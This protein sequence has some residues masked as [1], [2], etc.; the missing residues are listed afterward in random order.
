[1][2]ARLAREP[3]E[4]LDV[5]LGEVVL[6]IEVLGRV[7]GEGELGQDDEF[8]PRVAGVGDRRGDQPGVALDVADGGVDLGERNRQ[9]HWGVGSLAHSMFRRLTD[10]AK[11]GGDGR[12]CSRPRSAPSPGRARLA[13]QAP[14]PPT[15]AAASQALQAAQQAL[16]A[17]RRP[18]A[19]R[20]RRRPR[21]R[22]SP[23]TG[24][25]PPTPSSGDRAR[26][27]ARGLLARPTDG[28]ADRFGDGYPA[29]APV[30]SAESPHFCVFW[31]SDPGYADAPDLADPNG[32]PTATGPRLRR[33][34]DR[35]R[36]ALLR[37][38]GRAGTARLGAPEARHARAVAPTR[39]CGR[40]ST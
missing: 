33:V 10:I 12:P 32:S 20:D 35:D 23:S 28:A 24:S 9:S 27:E 25:P 6:E 18:D 38:R 2:P 14:R 39:A 34:A 21:P 40:T 30:A 13:Q 11:P 4:R 7:T 37:G 5:R 22:A 3:L 8:R 36:R 16:G 17:G 15:P 19:A 26:R 29:G 31:V 1:M